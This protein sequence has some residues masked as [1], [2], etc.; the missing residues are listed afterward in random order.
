MSNRHWVVIVVLAVAL[1]A[2]GGYFTANRS[3]RAAG[4]SS[5]ATSNKTQERE[6]LYWH[7]P[8]VPS[9]KFDKPGKS[10]FMD[11]Q[12]VPVY[13]GDEN[14]NGLTISSRVAQNLGIRL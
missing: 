8:M 2:A 6:V 13:A 7:D 4:T 1:S 3:E 5:V 12:L 14:A 10:P 11:M 9:A